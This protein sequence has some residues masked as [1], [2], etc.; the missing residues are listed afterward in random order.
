MKIVPIKPAEAFSLSLEEER[1]FRGKPIPCRISGPPGLVRLVQQGRRKTGA[2]WFEEPVFTRLREKARLDLAA[3]NP[4]NKEPFSISMKEMVGLYMKHC[5]RSDLAI[6]KNWTENFDS[7]AVLPLRPVDSLVAWVG[8]IADQPYYEKPKPGD[9]TKA[10][11]KAK[12]AIYEQAE[13]GGVSLL[14]REKQYVIRFD[15]AANRSFE[16]RIMGPWSF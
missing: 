15:H 6:C 11:Y 4:G 12:L 8:M 7:Y 5:L 16:S 14:A 3:Q 10:E 9:Y 1:S 2:F 13:R